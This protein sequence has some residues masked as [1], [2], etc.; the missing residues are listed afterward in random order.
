LTV[1]GNGQILNIETT[2][3][4]EQNSTEIQLLNLTFQNGNNNGNGGVVYINAK[5]KD[6]WAA[7]LNK[8]AD[9]ENREIKAEKGPEVPQ[10]DLTGN[11]DKEMER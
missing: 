9:Q 10:R 5:Y 8:T 6:Q 11:S 7:D 4:S 1:N 3:S 2:R